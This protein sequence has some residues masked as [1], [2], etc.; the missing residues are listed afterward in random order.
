MQYHKLEG[1]II[2]KRAVGEANY[3]V[4]IFTSSVGKLSCFARG[5]RSIRSHR[6]SSLD[7]FSLVRFEVI[8][9]QGRN[10]LT[11][12]E[13]VNSFRQNKAALIHISRLFQIGELIDALTAENDPHPQVY[14]LLVIALTHLS[15]FETPEYLYRFKTR[16]LKELGFYRPGLL[17]DT[18]DPFIE[19]ILN[20]SLKSRVLN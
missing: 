10:T 11:H 15:R 16:L 12:V 7:L 2:N 1:I 9:K 20:R 6:L 14:Q 5:A 17:P 4:T 19:S 18:I 8:E 13:L 3:F